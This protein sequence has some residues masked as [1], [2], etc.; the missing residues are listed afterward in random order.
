MKIPNNNQSVIRR[1]IRRSFGSNRTRN[2]FAVCAIILTTLMISAVFSMGLSFAENYAVMNTRM[3]GSAAGI[4]LQNPSPSQ[5]EALRSRSYLGAVGVEIDAGRLISSALGENDENICLL[6]FDETGWEKHL[7]PALGDVEGQYPAAAAEIMA[8]RWSLGALGVSDIRIGMDIPLAY[9]MPDG[10]QKH[11]VFRLSGLFT[12]YASSNSGSIL[13]SEAFVKQEGLS[14]SGNG[15]ASLSTGMFSSQADALSR[16]KEEIPLA[17]GQEFVSTSDP[18]DENQAAALAAGLLILIIAL[19]I[20]ASGYLLIYNIL[21]IAVKKDIH[22]YGLLK[23]LGASPSQIRKIVKAQAR[24]FCLIGIPSGLL[25]GAGFSFLLVPLFLGMFDSGGT[26][27]PKNISFH[28]AIFLG[29]TLFSYLTT[30][31][32]CIRPAKTASRIS[33]VEALRYTGISEKNQ[34]KGRRSTDGGKIYKMALHNVFR[35][36]KRA[37][38]VF[39][40]LF[41]GTITFLSV[42][43]M[44]NSFGVENYLD[45]YMPYDFQLRNLPPVTPKFDE[46]FLEQL[47]AL[48]GVESMTVIQEGTARIEYDPTLF[49][50]FLENGIGIYMH[51]GDAEDA[52][53]AFERQIRENPDVYTADLILATRGQIEKMNRDHGTNVDPDAFERGE[54][55]LLDPGMT[56]EA[57]AE[58]IDACR[59]MSFTLTDPESGRTHTMT[60]AGRVIGD[61]AFH[62]D[63]TVNI[64]NI[65]LSEAALSR[66]TDNPIVTEIGLHVAEGREAA[67]GAAISR[68]VEGEQGVKL[69]ARSQKRQEFLTSI[70]SLNI[71]GGGMALLLVLIGVLNF[72]NIM[73]TGITVRQNELAVMESVGM[74]RR[75]IKRML[76]FEG[77]FYAGFT[78]L[79]IITLGSAILYGVSRLSVHIADYAVFHYPFSALGVMLL[80]IVPICFIVPV[81]IYHFVSR[82][83]V[84]ERLRASED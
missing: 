83:S 38:V 2:I 33:P 15:R 54:T 17:A 84:V 20:M 60:F 48:D 32:S 66:L 79:L 49:R 56:N 64:P 50:P 30:M 62:S 27:M 65:Y 42:T 73:V 8:S 72:V 81:I 77:L 52:V 71:A 5:M 24:R 9:E 1:I 80:A 74:T 68:M 43:S 75:Q 41:L 51:S 69:N 58:K 19:F 7:L 14:V 76:I 39:L 3:A 16:L 45:E 36:K 67:I 78:S 11:A 10:V 53:A 82:Q 70:G 23:T 59:G 29:T 6:Y 63:M 26:P 4:Y 28:P 47:R 35:D 61:F 13:V 37:A 31:I 57:F 55:A 21:F 44:V 18:K 46:A 22:F 40:S 34:K 12:D 25:L